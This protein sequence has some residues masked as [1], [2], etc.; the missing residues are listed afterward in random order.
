MFQAHVTKPCLRL[1]MEIQLESTVRGYH[2]YCWDTTVSEILP[3]VAKS[4]N[5]SDRFAVTVIRNDVVIGHI[6]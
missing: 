4:S 6:P 2:L 1:I 5:S 3:C